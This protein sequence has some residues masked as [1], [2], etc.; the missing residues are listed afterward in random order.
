MSAAAET[1]G[2]GVARIGLAIG[3]SSA[4]GYAL[5]A[6]VGRALTP[7]E[8]GLFVAFWGVLF[9]LGASLANIEQ[10]TA[11]QAASR[12]VEDAGPPPSA[13]ITAAAVIAG[14]V[15]AATLLPPLA[16]R[17]YGQ[18]DSW[19]GLLVVAAAL[20]F[21]VQ[22]GVRGL[23]IG[24]GAMRSYALLVVAEASTRLIVLLA[25]LALVELTLF[26]A[27]AAVAAGAIAWIAWARHARRLVP[28]TGLSAA[29]WRAAVRRAASLMVAAALTASVITGYPTL[30]TALTDEAPGAA[31]GVVFAA[32]TVSRV[33]LLLISPI[34]AVAVPF[35]VR[36]R[37]DAGSDGGSAAL[38]KGLLLGTALFVVLGFV[39]AAAAWAAGPWVVRLIYGSRYDVAATA[40]ALLVL[41]ACL[42]AWLQLLSAA[43]IALAAHR[44]ML[45]TWV[46]AVVST[47]AWLL[48]SPLDVVATTAVG[49]L[50]GP[51][52]ALV[53]AVPML[54]RLA[55]NQV[56]GTV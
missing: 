53:F 40:M 7:A 20:G 25:I 13:V 8:F 55:R 9:G 11:R 56:P 52:A 10:E 39:A 28:G 31:G 1:T 43:L 21:S 37:S 35:V 49:S 23:L 5:L 14:L 51:V 16:E 22:F 38:R 27:A 47:V 3:I 15:G 2:A 6:L 42:L 34:Q 46:V 44:L 26:T 17:L 30:V 48:V 18:A 32:L 36:A 54:W 4:A 29:T 45:T 41:S 50:V 12:S 33:P 24:S 19:I